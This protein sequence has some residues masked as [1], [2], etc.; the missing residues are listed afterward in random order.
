MKT[1]TNCN[2]PM[3]ETS[4]ACPKCKQTQP[5]IPPADEK[6]DKGYIGWA[7]ISLGLGLM[8]LFFFGGAGLQCNNTMLGALTFGDPSAQTTGAPAYVSFFGLFDLTCSVAYWTIAILGSL[9]LFVWTFTSYRKGL[10]LLKQSQDASP[11]TVNA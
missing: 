7:W 5:L 9:P 11:S 2:T 1:C 8:V 3:I 6:P 10:R 4:P